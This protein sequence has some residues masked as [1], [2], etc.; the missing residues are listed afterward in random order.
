MVGSKGSPLV[1]ALSKRIMSITEAGLV[2]H[3]IKTEEPNSTVCHR[4]PTKVTVKTTLS[5]INIWGMFVI[6]AAGHV[7]SVSVLYL[8]L[9]KVRLQ[10]NKNH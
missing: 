5:L 1:P 6:L 9:L 4:V 10:N 2:F 7:V 8:E 3:W